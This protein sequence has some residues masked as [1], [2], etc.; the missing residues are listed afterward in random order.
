MKELNRMCNIAKI[1][2]NDNLIT[3]ALEND[4]NSKYYKT[5]IIVK[6][7]DLEQ[8]RKFITDC[9]EL[10]SKPVTFKIYTK[11]DITKLSFNKILIDNN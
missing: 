1:V 4:I 8:L 11:N 10:I 3:F 9:D 2:F 6:E 7:N 5:N